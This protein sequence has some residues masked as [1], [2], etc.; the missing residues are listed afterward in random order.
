MVFVRLRCKGK[1]EVDENGN[2]LFTE[3]GYPIISP[4]L[5]E[6]RYKWRINTYNELT[7]EFEV[8]TELE[9]ET[10][11]EKLKDYIDDEFLQQQEQKI[12][13]IKQLKAKL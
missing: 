5:P 6:H 9:D 8:I 7:N 4:D 1:Q 12:A 13:K 10:E 2:P 3:D 11:A